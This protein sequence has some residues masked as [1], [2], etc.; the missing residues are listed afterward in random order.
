MDTVGETSFATPGDR[1]LE[2]TRTFDAPRQA[3]FDAFTVRGGSAV[4]GPAGVGG[5]R[6]RDRPA[7]GRRL[8]VHLEESPRVRGRERWDVS[9]GLGV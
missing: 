6:V 7:T 3:V 1:E 5:C 9:R 8:P 2:I 4:E